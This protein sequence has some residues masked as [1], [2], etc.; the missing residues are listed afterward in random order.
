M[1]LH[2]MISDT[3]LT[4]VTLSKRAKSALT[5]KR[6]RYSGLQKIALLTLAVVNVILW[7]F[8]Y[9]VWPGKEPPVAGSSHTAL[10]SITGIMYS[11]NK[12]SAIM[13]GKEVHQGDV[14]DGYKVMKIG[15]REVVFE[16]D[17]RVISKQ[18]TVNKTK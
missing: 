17:G 5:T 11:E 12:P 16:K 10:G 8:V 9:E 6:H 1:A 7:A 18:V 4:K 13:H 14:V 2:Y 15:R 3:E